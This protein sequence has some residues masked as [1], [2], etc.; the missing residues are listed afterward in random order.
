MGHTS[1]DRVTNSVCFSPDGTR[2]VAGSADNTL[3]MWDA[4]TGITTVLKR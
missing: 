1:L 4:N 3:T 2:I